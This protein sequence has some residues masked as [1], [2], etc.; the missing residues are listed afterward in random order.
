MTTNELPFSHP[1]SLMMSTGRAGIKPC[2]S[3]LHRNDRSLS[4]AQRLKR[5]AVLA[6]HDSHGR[7]P[8]RAA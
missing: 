2:W 4:S 8:R 1:A 7:R 5:P 3:G 6:E